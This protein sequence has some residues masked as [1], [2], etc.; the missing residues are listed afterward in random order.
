M[1]G[2]SFIL[3]DFYSMGIGCIF[4]GVIKDL[5]IVG[6]DCDFSGGDSF[7]MFVYNNGDGNVWISDSYY[8]NNDILVFGVGIMVNVLVFM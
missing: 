5:V 2:I 4:V 7:D 3:C 6:W 1:D 8:S